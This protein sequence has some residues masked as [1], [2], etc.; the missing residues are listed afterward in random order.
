MS[1]RTITHL[2]IISMFLFVTGCVSSGA[3]PVGSETKTDLSKSNYKVIKA[4]AR[5]TDK[6]FWLLGIIPFASPNYANAMKDL[7]KQIDIEG[8][9]AS[10]ANITKDK[11]TLYL[12]LFSVPKIIVT[13]DV[14]EFID[15]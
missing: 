1:I 6:G 8:K 5:G 4:N 11:S 2:M 7:H 15:E 9:S 14:I 12:I 13:A 3:L 10:L